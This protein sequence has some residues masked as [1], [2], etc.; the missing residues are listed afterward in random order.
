MQKRR[1]FAIAALLLSLA[2]VATACAKSTSSDNGNGSGTSTGGNDLLAKIKADGKIRVATDPN[3]KPQSFLTSDGVMQGFDVDVANELAKRLGVEVEWVTPKWGT[4]ISGRWNDRWDVSVGSM[5][6][7][8]ERQDVLDFTPGYRFDPAGIAVNV[9]D[10]TSSDVA[11]DFDGK[12]IGV[13]GGCT[14]QYY[15]EK[16]LAAPGL[17]PDF[18][19]DDANIKTYETDKNAIADLEVGRLDAVVSTI[20]TLQDSAADKGEIRVLPD[21]LYKE[22]VSVALD[23]AA[24]LDPTSL[25]DALTAELAAMQADG[26]MTAISK[27]WYG[28]DRT[29]P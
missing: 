22:P 12:T 1:A 28:D 4:I 9:K 17:S 24:P 15:L 23:K 5:T 3:Y 26:T 18:V 21:V 20:A 7:L 2:L 11:T 10:T 13:C 25:V 27:K 6:P 29:Q 19:I 14:Y 16:T 8:P